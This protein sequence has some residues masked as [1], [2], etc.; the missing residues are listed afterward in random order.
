MRI[1]NKTSLRPPRRGFVSLLTHHRRL[2]KR[3]GMR[4]KEPEAGDLHRLPREKPKLLTQTEPRDERT[5]P[6]DVHTSQVV[7]QIPTLADIF[8]RPRLEW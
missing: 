6:L 8:S 1:S 5:V 7:Q 2:R 4:Q 3:T